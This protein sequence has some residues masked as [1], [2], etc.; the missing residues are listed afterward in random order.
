MRFFAAAL[1]VSA[2]LVGCAGESSDEKGIANLNC[3]MLGDV[4]IWNNFGV[5]DYVDMGGRAYRSD[6]QTNFI[7]GREVPSLLFDDGTVVSFVENNQYPVL[8]QYKGK[9]DPYFCSPR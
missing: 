2:I 1:M 3:G 8:I 9:G 7:D 5:I 4:D 6:E